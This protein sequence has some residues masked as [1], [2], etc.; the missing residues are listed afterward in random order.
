MASSGD[1]VGGV[2]EDVLELLSSDVL[3]DKDKTL[4]QCLFEE[5]AYVV[6]TT[7]WQYLHT[8][9]LLGLIGLDVIIPNV[10]VDNVVAASCL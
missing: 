8:L 2:F 7:T 9:L 10:M 1:T 4:G 5:G 6:Y 3:Q